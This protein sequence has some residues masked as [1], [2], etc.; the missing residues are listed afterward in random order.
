MDSNGD[1]LPPEWIAPKDH[2]RNGTRILMWRDADYKLVAGGSQ[3]GETN[4][5]VICQDIVAT[6]GELMCQM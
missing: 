5:G 1:A 6:R 4:M 2:T 3:V